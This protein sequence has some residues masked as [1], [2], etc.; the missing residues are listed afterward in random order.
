[1][2]L[3][4]VEPTIVTAI[5]L[6]TSEVLSVRPDMSVRELADFLAENEISGAPVVDD[7]EKLIGV[8]SAT[9][10]AEKSRAEADFIVERSDPRFYVRSFDDT[11]D[12]EEMRNLHI[13]NEDM[14]VR[15]IMTP[16]AITVPADLPV[17]EIAR[18][19]VSGRIHRVFVTNLEGRMIGIVTALDLLKILGAGV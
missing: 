14:L 1:M 12:V 7:D 11:L 5:D 15:D 4:G 13:E 2:A 18:E 8:V 16:K 17:A 6:M 19:M 3:A 9:D 10:I